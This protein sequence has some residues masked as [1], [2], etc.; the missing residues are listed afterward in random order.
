VDDPEERL[1]FLSLIAGRPVDA[2]GDLTRAEAGKAVIVLKAAG[3][4][5]DLGK[6]SDG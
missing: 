3:T 1:G 4:R 6:L 2:V 5:A